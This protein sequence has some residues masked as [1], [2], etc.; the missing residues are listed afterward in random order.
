MPV[1]P[2]LVAVALL[3]LPTSV[4]H[5]AAAKDLGE[6]VRVAGGT[7][8][9]GSNDGPADE[10]PRHRVDVEAFS[11]DRTKVTN[12]QFAEFLNAVGL[13]GPKGENYFDLDDSDARVHRRGGHHNI[14]FR[15][16]R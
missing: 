15:C 6:M 8:M 16:A 11:I 1:D 7:F 12:V 5:G 3:V 10:R 13:K 2:K 4:L 14:S 9:M